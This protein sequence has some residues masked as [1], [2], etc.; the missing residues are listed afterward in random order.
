MAAF[1]AQAKDVPS[2]DRMFHRAP[3]ATIGTARSGTR[4]SALGVWIFAAPGQ[5]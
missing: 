4:Y 1:V 3:P 2:G 5:T